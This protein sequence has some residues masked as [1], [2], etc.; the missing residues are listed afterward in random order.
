MQPHRCCTVEGWATGLFVL[1]APQRLASHT[2]GCLHGPG[3]CLVH[4]VLG[5][6]IDMWM[7]EREAS[8]GGAGENSRMKVKMPQLRGMLE[9]AERVDL[10]K[11]RQLG[12]LETSL[13]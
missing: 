3:C 11:L 2:A 7:W 9:R 4:E 5:V 8:H 6:H 12:I 10:E 13:E 1:S